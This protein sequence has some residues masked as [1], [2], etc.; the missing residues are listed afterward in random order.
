MDGPNSSSSGKY[1]A[2]ATSGHWN[3]IVVDKCKRRR[4]SGP[5][6]RKIADDRLS[7]FSI[8]VLC[9]VCDGISWTLRII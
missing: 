2:A 7:K 3:L 8:N 4:Q 9:L 6:G 1:L 5:C